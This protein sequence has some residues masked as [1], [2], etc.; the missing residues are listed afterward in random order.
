M[1]LIEE[2]KRGV[3]WAIPLAYAEVDTEKFYV[4]ENLHLIGLMNTADRSLAM[5]DYAL[6]RRFAFVD[7]LP[8]FS[9]S[10]FK[11][12][13]EAR[14]ASSEM[15]DLIR[16]RMMRLNEKI[17]AEGT[18]LGPGFCIGHSF[19]CAPPLNDDYSL[20]W[21]EGIVRTEIEP[22]VRE[23][24]FDNQSTADSLINELLAP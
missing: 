8:A 14:G 3:E 24:W 5:V 18:D 23:Y 16:T 13:L 12:Y 9:S 11:D 4:P 10:R 2:D 19:F 15:I 1:M 6:R 20:S 7:L 22:L 17:S 21:Y